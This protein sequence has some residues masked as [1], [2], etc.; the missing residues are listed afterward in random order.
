M[1]GT[2]VYIIL[3][4]ID[5]AGLCVENAMA[6]VIWHTLLELYSITAIQAPESA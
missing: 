1:S 2:E 4:L 6:A 5:C 3:S